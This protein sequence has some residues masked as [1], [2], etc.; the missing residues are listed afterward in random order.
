MWTSLYSGLFLFSSLLTLASCEKAITKQ[1]SQCWFWLISWRNLDKFGFSQPAAVV[2][3]SALMQF[4][5]QMCWLRN[6]APVFLYL[7]SLILTVWIQFQMFVSFV[8]SHFSPL[9]CLQWEGVTVW[10]Q[11]PS[12]CSLHTLS[13]TNGRSFTTSAKSFS[14]EQCQGRASNSQQTRC[15]GVMNDPKHKGKRLNPKPETKVKSSLTPPQ[16]TSAKPKLNNS[17][18]GLKRNELWVKK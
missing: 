10:N 11:L 17:S 14:D 18:T 6:T 13:T 15:L 1:K 3:F 5:I 8:A 4:I 12:L 9:W 16:K 2:L 7:L